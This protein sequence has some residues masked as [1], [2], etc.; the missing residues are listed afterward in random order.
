MISPENSVILLEAVLDLMD[1]GVALVDPQGAV[2]F[3]NAALA[4]FVGKP[5]AE[6]PA[7]VLWVDLWDAYTLDGVL[8]PPEERP[9]TRA[10]RTGLPYEEYL[11]VRSHVGRAQAKIHARAFPILAKDNG[12]VTG[13][14]GVIIDVMRSAQSATGKVASLEMLLARTTSSIN[15]MMNRRKSCATMLEAVDL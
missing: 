1:E 3:Y 11:V 8:L 15:V 2:L 14:V 10:L 4:P 12:K 9:M 6:Q 5:F 13:G 7:G